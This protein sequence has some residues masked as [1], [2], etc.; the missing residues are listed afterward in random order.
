MTNALPISAGNKAQIT[1]TPTGD[2]PASNYH[3]ILLEAPDMSLDV[4]DL[5]VTAP[6]QCQQQDSVYIDCA[7]MTGTLTP[8]SPLTIPVLVGSQ[9]P[10]VST[11]WIWNPATSGYLSTI[12]SGS[13][14]Y[15]GASASPESLTQGDEVAFT[16]DGLPPV[17]EDGSVTFTAGDVEMCTATLPQTSCT[18]TADL[19]PDY[20]PVVASYDGGSLL[21]PQSVTATDGISVYLDPAL[22][23]TATPNPA[24]VGAPVTVTA[25]LPADAT[26]T[27]WVDTWDASCSADVVDGTAS[28]DLEGLAPG[29]HTVEVYYGGDGVYA[30][31][32]TIVSLTVA[33]PAP[34]VAVTGTNK[35]LYV[36]H[37]GDTTWTNLG[38]ALIAAPAV[39]VVGD[40]EGGSITHYIGIGANSMLY[41][42]TDTTAWRRLTTLDYK[43]TQI[44]IAANP[45]AT[46]VVG[47][48]TAANKA[49]YTFTFDGSQTAPTVTTLTKRTADN[50]AF[51]QGAVSWDFAGVEPLPTVIVK[52]PGTSQ[53][54]TYIITGLTGVG[55]TH[56]QH[57]STTGPGASA[58]GEYEAY[59]HAGSTMTIVTRDGHYDIGCASIGNPAIVQNMDGSADLYVTGLNGKTYTRHL[60]TTASPG[61][62]T[63]ID[64]A[65]SYGT[66]AARSYLP[67]E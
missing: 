23:A 27:V 4:A 1:I 49:L 5:S 56:Y 22:T 47:A 40:G 17:V 2:W 20:Y 28:C 52:G 33:T 13:V 55:A 58:E 43:C 39:S 6:Y 24:P 35:A 30:D 3:Q 19:D 10:E 26:G 25:T 60:T 8:Y 38:G 36:R 21:N 57:A 29:E 15:L 62:W 16:L 12:W 18:T 48:C 66:A 34:T 42:R 61:G 11:V 44:A 53:G 59:Q 32:S 37:D 14:S 31:D 9:P 51:T 64:G 45:T 50:Q 67:Q 63:V 65:T 54:D 41:Q 46:D 7:I